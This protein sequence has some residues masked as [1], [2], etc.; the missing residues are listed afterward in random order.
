MSDEDEDVLGR[1]AVSNNQG[2]ENR[3]EVGTEEFIAGLG[4][5]MASRESAKVQRTFYDVSRKDEVNPVQS[6]SL[7]GKRLLS[8]VADHNPCSPNAGYT[9][10]LQRRHHLR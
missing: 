2:D 9:D 6:G 4:R 7:T 3:G 8:F 1:N 10:G 5:D